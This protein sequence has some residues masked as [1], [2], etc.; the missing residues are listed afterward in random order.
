MLSPHLH[1]Q[2][3]NQISNQPTNQRIPHRLPSTARRSSPWLYCLAGLLNKLTLF[4]YIQ[5]GRIDTSVLDKLSL[6]TETMK[7]IHVKAGRGEPFA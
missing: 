6:V 1:N 4:V 5:M 3:T 7:H 2:S